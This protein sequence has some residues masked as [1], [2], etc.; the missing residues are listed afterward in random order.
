MS[1]VFEG[2]PA[3]VSVI[4]SDQ[5]GRATTYHVAGQDLGVVKDAVKAALA[6]IPSQDEPVKKARKKYRQRQSKPEAIPTEAV[7]LAGIKH[8]RRSRRELVTAGTANGGDGGTVW[9]G[10]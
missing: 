10:K 7:D 5:E 9:P 3:I 2:T 4:V 8:S 1:E 6:A